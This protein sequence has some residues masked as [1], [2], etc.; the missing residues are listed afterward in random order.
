MDKGPPP[1]GGDQSQANK[2]ITVW[3]VLTSLSVAIV[4][5][6]FVARAAANKHFGWDDW[7]MLTALCL[8]V[9]K[10]GVDVSLTRTGYGRHIY[11]LDSAQVTRIGKLNF[12]SGLFTNLIICLVKLSVS[13]FLL[14]I[15]GLRPRL[16]AALFATIALL[17]S[18]TL[19]TVIILFVQCRPI[20]GIWDHKVA[21]TAKCL[22]ASALTD[23]SYCSTASS[24]FTDF[25]CATLPFQIIGNLQMSRRL[26]FSVLSLLCLS[27]LAMICGIVRI[28]LIESLRSTTDPTWHNCNLSVWTSAEFS[29]GII[30]GSIPP[31]RTFVL[32]AVH[33]F[34]GEAPPSGDAYGVPN[35]RRSGYLYPFKSLARITNRYSWSRASPE[36]SGGSKGSKISQKK[37]IPL[38]PWNMEANRAVSHDSGRESMLPLHSMP[39]ANLESGILKTVDVRVRTGE[40]DS[41]PA[42]DDFAHR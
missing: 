31:C 19:A 9:A 5:L 35:S 18:S 26:K 27:S 28:T 8:T 10:F 32:Q 20:A 36:V 22:P 40:V 6:R 2:L 37:Y 7:T 38:K 17:V 33:K 39:K 29:V 3:A 34:T 14:K 30:A 4:T 12:V 24:I 41:G 23:V 16:R 15:G 1:P 21:L 25:L 42:A 11:Y 13:M